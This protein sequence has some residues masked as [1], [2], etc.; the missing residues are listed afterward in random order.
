MADDIIKEEN[1]IDDRL[2]SR[3]LETEIYT[4]S[5][6]EM[7]KNAFQDNAEIYDSAFS[8]TKGFTEISVNAILQ[9][10]RI[11]KTLRYA[12]SPPISQ[13]KFGQF[14]GLTS[15][16][17]FEKK[18]L[19]NGAAYE[20]LRSIAKNICDYINVNIDRDRF[21][22]LDDVA[23]KTSIA[24]TFAKK[25]TCSVAANQ[26]AETA[27]RNWRK[28]QQEKGAHAAIEAMG[29]TKSAFR[30]VVKNS[31]D[32]AIGTYTCETRVKG[33]T[34]QKADIV[35]KSKKT[36]RLIL[37]EAKAVGVELDATKRIKECCDKANDWGT[38]VDLSNPNVVSLIA[39]FFTENNIKNLEAS[40]ITVV[41]EHNLQKL[42]EIL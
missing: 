15:I 40:N 10:T 41:W 3:R 31:T 36:N 16:D 9:D 32:I 35:C 24:E 19:K 39:G 22:W 25:W 29:Y 37:I 26:N 1:I 17:K 13:M 34:N 38:S 42:K 8:L 30:G 14:V 27:Y 28:D 11:I 4:N 23:R 20:Q 18:N 2:I 21:I 6:K 12:I 7:Y 33:R 5:L